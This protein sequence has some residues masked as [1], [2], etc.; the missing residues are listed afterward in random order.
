[1]ST[2][3]IKQ[4]AQESGVSI[5]TVSRVL[6]GTAPVAE[7]TRARVQAV[8]A[9]HNY[10]PNALA[11]GLAGHRTM[12]LGVILPDIANPYFA[13]MFREMETAA[14]SAG[15]SV[16]LCNTGFRA[17][18]PVELA[19]RELAAFQT[20]LDKAVDGVIVAGGQADLMDV[21]R[22]YRH[23]LSRLA[24]AVPTVV[25]G[26][27]IPGAKC[28]F[29]Q[30][31]RGLGVLAAVNY[32]VSLGHRRIAFVGGEEGVGITEA[33]LAAYADALSTLSLPYDRALVAPSDYYAPDG[34]E[35][36]HWLLGRGNPFTALL[37]MNDSVA[38]GAYRALADAGLAVPGD[39][40]VISCDQFFDAGF[41]VPRLTSIDQH[42][43][44]FGR[45]VINSL[46][47]VM[48]G[49]Q[50]CKPLGYRPELVVRESCA[51]VIQTQRKDVPE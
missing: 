25:I 1:M 18:G 41:F 14:R 50:A 51:P 32:L 17:A 11:R 27:P 24:A 39:V 46:L 16:L 9:R 5:A 44:R 31:E 26:D 7:S 43:S 15:Y 22:N 34:Y 4:I 10:T 49:S 48:G 36:V 2:I 42:N 29:I 45:F 40:S 8:M 12:T 21:G 19:H 33:R 6:N 28:L 38:L 30:R 35:A 3:T 47:A 13:S 23:A 20:M 37:A